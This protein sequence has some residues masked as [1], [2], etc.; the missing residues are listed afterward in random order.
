MKL[1][2]VAHL[3]KNTTVIIDVKVLWI[4]REINLQM[5]QKKMSEGGCR[6]GTRDLKQ[7]QR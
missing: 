4:N 7:V 5:S 3:A 2:D 6:N 1:R